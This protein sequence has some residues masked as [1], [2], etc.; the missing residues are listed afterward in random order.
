[1]PQAF[2]P[3]WQAAEPED[4]DNQLLELAERFYASK[5]QQLGA[6]LMRQLE[7]LLMLQVVDTLWVR[8]LTTLDELRVGIGLRA[9]GQK[10]PLVEYKREAF[11][12]FEELKGAISN[13]IAHKVYFVTLVKQQAPRPTQAYGPGSES[14]GKAPARKAEKDKVGRND[15]CP[16]GSGRKYKNCC[17]RKPTGGGGQASGRAQARASRRGKRR[18]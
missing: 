1:L 15:P 12:M 6:E 14:R 3:D 8:H 10:D 5:E 18:P 2:E 16:C 4:I 7:R 9:I 17:M 13:E 11:D